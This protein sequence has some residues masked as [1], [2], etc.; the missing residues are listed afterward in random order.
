[1]I[2]MLESATPSHSDGFGF[3]SSG[4]VVTSK[5]LCKVQLNSSTLIGY[6]LKKITYLDQIQPIFQFRSASIFEGRLWKKSSP[7]DL[8]EASEL[9]RFGLERLVSE[10]GSFVY[11]S[12]NDDQIICCRDPV[13]VTPIYLGESEELSGIASN[14]KMLHKAGIRNAAP[15]PPGKI[16]RINREGFEL[17]E[18][19]RLRP[20]SSIKVSEE[21]AVERIDTLISESVRVRSKRVSK[22]SLGFSGGI[23]SYL[24][25]YF[26]KENGLDVDL[27]CVGMEGSPDFEVAEK[28]ADSLG[29]PLR[30]EVIQSSKLESDLIHVVNSIEDDDPLNVSI[31]LPIYWTAKSASEHS[32][33]VFFT[34]GGS[35]ELFGGYQKYV[36]LYKNSTRRAEDMMFKDIV[37]S[38]RVNFERDFKVC[39]DLGIELRLPFADI[40]L[41]SYVLALPIYLKIPKDS[42]EPRKPLLRSLAIK[43]GL[44]EE[45]I[46]KQKKA[47]QYS[48]KVFR[49]MNRLAK[50]RGFTLKEFTSKIFHN[51]LEG[52]K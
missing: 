7:S 11:A 35:D 34:G 5:S 36:N 24:L 43:K 1:I 50:S 33:Q 40:D 30:A 41:I 4:G 44:D 39:T 9:V 8:I 29:L 18:A 2:K 42:K 49:E 22:A 51:A 31:A 14:R 13:G 12:T 19:G 37:E 26:L 3:G 47:I 23:D 10:N 25:A 27:I 17:R 48:T 6:R 46:S 20:R 38:Y 15:L 32:S 52:W 16:V 28:A 21:E 45:I